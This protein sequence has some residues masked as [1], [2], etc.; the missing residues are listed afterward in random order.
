MKPS[1]IDELSIRTE[2]LEKRQEEIVKKTMKAQNI[3]FC[4]LS[5]L[6]VFLI[7]IALLFVMHSYMLKFNFYPAVAFSILPI[8]AAIAVFINLRYIKSRSAKA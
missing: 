5:S 6:A 4:I 3:R 8:S 7:A 2:M 1:E